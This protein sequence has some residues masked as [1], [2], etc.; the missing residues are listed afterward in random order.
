[1][2]DN[3]IF[4]INNSFGS[5]N[6]QRFL[7]NIEISL[8]LA[9]FSLK[10]SFFSFHKKLFKEFT[11]DGAGSVIPFQQQGRKYMIYVEEIFMF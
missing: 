11:K 3:G 10:K 6:I 4:I 7:L 5:I 2:W 1:M 8:T 9:H